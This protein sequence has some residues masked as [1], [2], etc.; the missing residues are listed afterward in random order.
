MDAK[1]TYNRLSYANEIPEKEFLSRISGIFVKLSEILSIEILKNGKPSSK[2]PIERNIVDILNFHKENNFYNRDFELKRIFCL[3][4]DL[5]SIKNHSEQNFSQFKKQLKNCNRVSQYIGIRFEISLAS[6]FIK[7]GINY[8]NRESPDFEFTFEDTTKS[9]IETTSCHVVKEKEQDLYLKVIGTINTK[10]T[11]FYA[12]KSTIL[13]IDVTNLIHHSVRLDPTFK[14]ENLVA[15]CQDAMDQSAYGAFVFRCTISNESDGWLYSGGD[16]F[17]KNDSSSSLKI[18]WKK[19]DYNKR[20][21][22]DIEHGTYFC[23]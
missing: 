11:K 12:N 1:P 18:L 8:K 4:T 14:L 21:A 5:K 15:R 10:S 17:I 23:T 2:N 16:S 6:F 3:M 9:F 7:K 19:L 20:V 13:I 22:Q